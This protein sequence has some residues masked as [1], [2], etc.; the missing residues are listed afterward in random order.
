MR[1]RLVANRV[2]R[3]LYDDWP[4]LDMVEARVRRGSV[5]TDLTRGMT[6]RV[7]E[8]PWVLAHYK[9]E[10]RVLD[11][12]P[13]F[14]LPLY[15]RHLTRLGIPELHGIDLAPVRVPGMAMTH[16][17]VRHTPFADGTFDLI[18]CVS[19]LEHIGRDNAHYL[20]SAATDVEE[21]DLATLRELSR[22]LQPAGRILITVPFGRLDIQS[23]QKQYDLDAWQTLLHRAALRALETEFYGYSPTAGWRRVSDPA[24]L[25]GNEYRQAGA[26]GATA[27]CCAVLSHIQG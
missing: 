16:A 27:V 15:V 5:D 8:V 24:T 9:G 23:W 18:T 13:A 2:T 1:F 21:G 25:A 22:I 4:E 10:R 20:V 7:V 17:D 26:P 11:I 19:T 3:R 6:E 14:A 12:G